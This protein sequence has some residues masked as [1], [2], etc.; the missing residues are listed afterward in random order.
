VGQR[1]LRYKTQ[2]G[3]ARRLMQQLRAHLTCI[4]QRM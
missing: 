3:V 1:R 2:R 4:A